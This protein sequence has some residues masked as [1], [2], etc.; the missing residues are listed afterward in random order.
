MAWEFYE[1]KEDAALAG[2]PDGGYLV[3]YGIENS[4]TGQR[5][6]QAFETLIEAQECL[7]NVKAQKIASYIAI[8]Q[9]EI[10]GNKNY[11]TFVEGV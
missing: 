4:G 6:T 2:K 8:Y 3:E 10:Y 5:K 9:T 11:A 7:K 1:T